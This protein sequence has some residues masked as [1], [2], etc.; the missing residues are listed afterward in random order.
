[1]GVLVSLVAIGAVRSFMVIRFTVGVAVW[2]RGDGKIYDSAPASSKYEVGAESLKSRGVERCT[3]RNLD[4]MTPRILRS[5][6]VLYQGISGAQFIV[7]AGRGSFG[8]SR[9]LLAW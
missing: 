1:M 4:Q 7:N 3:N 5:G 9:A 6:C 8:S 2:L